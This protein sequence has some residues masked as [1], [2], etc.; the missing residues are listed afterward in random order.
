MTKSIHK[1]NVY[2]KNNPIDIVISMKTGKNILRLLI[3]SAL[4]GCVLSC[5][6]SVKK[7]SNV[8]AEAE[9]AAPDTLKTSDTR[10]AGK[11]PLVI[12]SG[13]ENQYVDWASEKKKADAESEAGFF[14]NPCSQEIRLIRA[15]S[16][17]PDQGAFNYKLTNVFDADPMTAWVE[18]SDSYGVGDFFEVKA[19]NVNMIYNGY[20]RTKKS[21]MD[22]S[23]VKK[24]MVFKDNTPLC[25]LELEDKMGGQHFTLPG[26]E[27]DD[28]E[29]LHNFRFEILEAYPG[30]KWE[31]VAISEIE[32]VTCCFAS[33]TVIEGL[34]G[35]MQAA[36]LE[37][38][39]G[40]M[41]IN[42]KTGQAIPT[43][44]KGFT[45]QTHIR[46]WEIV[47]DTKRMQMTPDHPVY[48]KGYGFI[49]LGRYM[50]IQ[51]I[52][53]FRHLVDHIELMTWNNEEGK[54][55]YETLRQI[56]SVEGEFD[57]YTV[58]RLSRGETYVANG[59]V[60]RVY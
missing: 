55:A 31:D 49:S 36:D 23:R 25:V 35:D 26:S 40:I 51:K 3:L 8:K 18:G 46:L 27:S 34:E 29:T 60:T 38:G 52:E 53:D 11:L 28:G 56:K 54:P 13:D 22:N 50:A 15:S 20:Q 16:T 37:N 21:W 43:E 33:S 12:A 48:V 44:V 4:S 32:H 47:T 6:P 42:L 58:L 45:R 30:D 59:F 5:T 9:Q 14:Y 2:F 24:F 1:A 41:G 17:L 39:S 10:P 7:E 19:R 57:T